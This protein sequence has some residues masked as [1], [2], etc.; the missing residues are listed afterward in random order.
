MKNL[1]LLAL[2]ALALSSCAMMAPGTANYTLGAQ[3]GA[4]TAGVTPVGTLM[5]SG[6]TSPMYGMTMMG[7][8]MT[9]MAAGS[10]AASGTTMAGGSMMAGGYTN[11]MAKITGLKPATYYVAHFHVQGTAS[12]NPCSSNGAPIISTATVGQ[13]DASG[14]LMLSRSVSKADTMNATY[15][16]VHTAADA[17]GTP[18]DAGVACTAVSVNR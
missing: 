1:T 9:D 17:S 3:P 18:A 16:N 11:T 15:W 6:S 14:T 2:G 7:G 8:A 4:A 10:T 12:T 5:V 13:T